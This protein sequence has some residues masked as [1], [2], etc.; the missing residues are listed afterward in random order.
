M[1]VDGMNIILKG[2]ELENV[3]VA[4]MMMEKVQN[5]NVFPKKK[6]QK[7]LGTKLQLR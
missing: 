5:Q 4:K 1:V 3:L 2:K 7:C 6:Q